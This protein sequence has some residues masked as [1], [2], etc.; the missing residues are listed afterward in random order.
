M[1]I[2]LFSISPRFQIVRSSLYKK[3]SQK[4]KKKKK[5]KKMCNFSVFIKMRYFITLSILV[6]SAL[7][8][9]NVTDIS[10]CPPLT[11]RDTPATNVRDLRIDDIKVVGALGDR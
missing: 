2:H 11:S 7:A 1:E 3:G 10:Q 6:T 9:L 8:T 4:K 5:K